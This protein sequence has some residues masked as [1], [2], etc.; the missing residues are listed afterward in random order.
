[1]P[2]I[3]GPTTVAPRS[4]SAWVDTDG[5]TNIIVGVKECLHN[6]EFHLGDAST[7]YPANAEYGGATLVAKAAAVRVTNLS[8]SSSL[9]FEVFE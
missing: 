1:M 8:V 6:V 7:V 4:S 5:I 9:S 3:Q 2:V